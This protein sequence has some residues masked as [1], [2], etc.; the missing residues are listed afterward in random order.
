MR[1]HPGNDAD[2]ERRAFQDRFGDELDRIDGDIDVVG[3][4][5]I[6]TGYGDSGGKCCQK[7]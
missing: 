1:G 5:R 6:G 7:G 2:R 4:R 3:D